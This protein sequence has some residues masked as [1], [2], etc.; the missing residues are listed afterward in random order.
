MT[1]STDVVTDDTNMSD[2]ETEPPH[3]SNVA[4][5]HKAKPTKVKFVFKLKKTE[6]ADVSQFHRKLLLEILSL[7]KDVMFTDNKQ[8]SI[9]PRTTE[10]F[11]P[12]FDYESLPRKHFQLV[13]VTHTITT[14]I[15]L[16]NLKRDLRN[17]LTSYRAT[18]NVNNWS[19]LD[20][21]DVGWI[22]S[23]H[24]RFHNRDNITSLL[25]QELVALNDNNLV[26]NFRVY[27]KTLT[28]N[29]PSDKQ[30]LV[31]QALHI[32]CES[33]NLHALRELL[34]RLY[35]SSNPRIPG[36]FVPVNFQH[37]QSKNAFLAL[38]LQQK[39]Y[40]ENHRNITIYGTSCTDLATEVQYDNKNKSIK[41]ILQESPAIS[42]IS[43]SPSSPDQW[44]IS[45][46]NVH[47]LNACQIV[48]TTILNNITNSSSNSILEHDNP[49]S[50]VLPLSPTT[51]NYLQAL[52][53]NLSLP[54]S[55]VTSPK[56]ISKNT[57]F[58]TNLSSITTST[59]Q[60]R[61]AIQID[62]IKEHIARS[63]EAI[64]T[65][66]TNFQESLRNEMKEQISTFTNT[67]SSNEQHLNS[68]VSDELSH[69]ISDIKK[70]LQNF[71]ERIR[72]ELKNE[73]QIAIQTTTSQLTSMITTEVN[74]ALQT[75]LQ[76]LSPRNQ[77]PKRSRSPNIPET[78]PQCL[79]S[80]TNSNESHDTQYDV[81]NALFEANMT[82]RP[83]SPLLY[84][85]DTEDHPMHQP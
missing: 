37:I 17:V 14:T 13:C 6:K 9:S 15:S 59:L 23:M 3:S 22:L 30:R 28:N 50:S 76:A 35:S 4:D 70:E 74:N 80:H 12:Y 53:T 40:L 27:S 75:Q 11:K 52:T 36:K 84:D 66:F 45:T 83:N 42:W 5:N 54:K 33:S 31:M 16:S 67:S 68:T 58:T 60:K 21:R 19:T 69:S 63:L 79:F 34:H 44:N 7:D 10:D 29:K 2:A 56:T 24:P 39:Q 81:A 1:T 61:T 72:A 55:T 48:K 57:T 78:L 43:P 85:S 49:S 41:T 20:V 8:Q 82:A 38:V 73:L 46:T 65:E 64:R 47:Y 77:K 26:P 18:L 51:K 32:E 71:R 25:R 62:N